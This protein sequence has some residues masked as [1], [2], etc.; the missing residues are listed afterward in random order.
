MT[1]LKKLIDQNGRLFGLISVIDVAVVA[2]VAVLAA[3]L[4][5]KGSATPIASI[6]APMDPIT[7]ELTIS[8]MPLGRLDSLR[9][10]DPLFDQETFNHLGNITN[11]AVEDCRISILK[12]DGTFDYADVEGR[13]NVVLTVQ[14]QAM[15]DERQHIYVNRT[16]LVAVG[17]SLNVYT[18]ASLFSG[19]ITGLTA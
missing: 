6:A 3:A 15:T 11:I 1:T 4:L 5:F 7:Y 9:V 16:N 12:T 14:A 19:L 10:G 13:Y 8:N 17:W 18:Q 2:V